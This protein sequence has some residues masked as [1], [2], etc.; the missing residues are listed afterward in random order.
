[1]KRK[2]ILPYG[3]QSISRDDIRSV[4]SA[5]KNDFLTTGP[6]VEIF[7]RQ[8]KSLTQA[9]HAVACANGTAAL[10]LACNAINLQKGDWVI[11]PSVTFLATANAVR[12]CGADVFFSDVD[13]NTGQITPEILERAF[14]EA[15][16]KSL[17]IKAV[18]VVHLTGKPVNL[19]EISF[20]TKK[21][22]VTLIVDACHA[23]GGSY[24]GSPIGS[25]KYED[26]NTFSFHPVKSITTGEGGAI[27]TNDKS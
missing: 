26:M 17:K 19:K 1:M 6:L 9:K 14:K 8:L 3:F 27:T 15:D 18:I 12:F 25:C 7:E 16:R 10:H 2:K 22:K 5:L 23:I 13:E 24:L 21:R 4:S 11:V 20:I